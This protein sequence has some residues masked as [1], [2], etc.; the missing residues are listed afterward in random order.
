MEMWTPIL[1]AQLPQCPNV[2]TG[3]PNAGSTVR[4]LKAILEKDLRGLPLDAGFYALAETGTVQK[5]QC[6]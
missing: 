2:V 5:I 1:A 6:S 4:V 3:I